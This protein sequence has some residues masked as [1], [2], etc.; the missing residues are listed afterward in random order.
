VFPVVANNGGANMISA[1]LHE[2]DHN[3]QGM[4]TVQDSDWHWVLS[5]TLGQSTG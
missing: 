2:F 5:V 3:L 4:A 1:D